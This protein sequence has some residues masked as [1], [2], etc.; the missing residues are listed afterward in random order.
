MIRSYSEL[1]KLKS[2]SE[3][4]EYLKL[5]DNNALSPRHMS[6]SFYKSK[7]WETIRDQILQR[8]LGFDLGVFGVYIEGSMYVHHINPIE[9]HDIIYLTDKLINPENLITTSGTTHN[10]IHYSQEE[11]E[12]PWVERTPGDTILWQRR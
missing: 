10:K 1:I 9:E 2:Y 5:Y 12:K 8:D 6:E 3:R 11:P 7:L 4:L